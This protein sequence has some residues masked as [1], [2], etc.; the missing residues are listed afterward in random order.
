MKNINNKN[1]KENPSIDRWEWLLKRTVLGNNW[2]GLH[3]SFIT[4]N[5]HFRELIDIMD[6]VKDEANEEHVERKMN[7]QMKLKV[8]IQLWR[9]ME[10]KLKRN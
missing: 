9:R 2:R 4:D 3:D 10:R 7:R 5:S 6:Y 8:K 1:L